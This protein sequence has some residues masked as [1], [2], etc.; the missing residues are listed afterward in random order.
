MSAPSRACLHALWSQVF[1]LLHMHLYLHGHN[2]VMHSP[3]LVRHGPRLKESPAVAFKRRGV[4]L[5]MQLLLNRSEGF[6]FG[7]HTGHLF[8]FSFLS[9]VGTT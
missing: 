1:L 5:F 7:G 6:V 3:F 8:Y 4:A 2:G 9:S